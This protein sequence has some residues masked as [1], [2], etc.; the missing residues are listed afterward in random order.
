M[1][2]IAEDIFCCKSHGKSSSMIPFWDFG[3]LGRKA[4]LQGICGELTVKI[5]YRDIENNSGCFEFEVL[6]A[7]APPGL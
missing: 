2:R 1:Q 5:R 4:S 6:H 3:Q 7:S